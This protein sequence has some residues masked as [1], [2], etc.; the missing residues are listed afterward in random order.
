MELKESILKSLSLKN[1][2]KEF[3]ILD[4]NKE[5]EKIVPKINEMKEVGECKY[6]VV[7]CFDHSINA[8]REFEDMIN[9]ENF[10][11]EHL[12]DLVWDYL[13]TKI[14]SN[15]SRLEIL[16]LGIFIHDIGKPDAKTVDET[17]RVHFK[18]HEK[19]G[20]DIAI[21]LGKRLSLSEKSID[22]LFNY[23]RYHMI[24]LVFYKKNNL[25]KENLFEVFDKI[26]EDII[27]IMLLGYADIVSTRK[28]LNPDEKVGT[29]KTYM[30]FI[31]TNY[32]YRYKRK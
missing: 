11:P 27:G 2:S 6:H 22:T 26:G 16:K 25:T 7:N 21:K 20:G 23:V 13:N 17:G 18:G 3:K 29:I 24:L 30:E 4:K 12:K 8:L 5:L 14:E 28:L 15:I 1:T 32:E 19:I 9:N 10:F 31:L